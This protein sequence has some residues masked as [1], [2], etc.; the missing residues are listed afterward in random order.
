[1]KDE[2]K[3]ENID[4]KGMSCSSCV[5]KIEKRLSKLKGIEEVKAN[6][7]KGKVYV[8]F[9]PKIIK[10]EEIKSEIEDLGYKTDLSGK[11]P[12]SGK[13]SL[14]HGI[15]YGLAPHSCCIGFILA[16]IV[17]ATAFTQ[18]FKPLLLNPYFFYILIAISSLFATISVIIYFKRLGFISIR[19]NEDGLELAIESEDIKRKWKYLSTLY[20]TTIGVNLLFFLIIFPIVTNM[21]SGSALANVYA[22]GNSN[23]IQTL[24]LQVNIP[25]PGHVPLITSELKSISGVINVK[26][27]FPNIFDVY[28]DASKTSKE[29]ILSLDVFKTYKASVLGSVS[30]EGLNAQPN[31]NNNQNLNGLGCGVGSCGCCGVR[32]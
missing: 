20:G 26:F 28:Y 1:M 21:T 19:K 32:R 2:L 8:K 9:N 29:Q 6:L 10:L 25:C 27:S 17:G 4:V 30:L 14:I 15:I 31:S 11:N 13:C 12:K 24:R 22:N 18:L 16:S 7:A 3:E 5:Q 23:N